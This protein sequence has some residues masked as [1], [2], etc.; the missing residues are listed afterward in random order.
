MSKDLKDLQKAANKHFGEGSV[1][2]YGEDTRTDVDVIPTGIMSLDK[3]LGIGGIPRGRMIEIF[4]PESTGKTTL[5]LYVAAQAQEQGGVVAYV[6]T[7]HSLDLS[8]AEILGVNVEELLISQPDTAEKALGIIEYL[9]KSGKVSVIVLDSIAAL[10]PQAE[11]EGDMGQ[12][13]IGLTA[14]LMSQACR[15]LT[16][17]L[18]ETNTS[19]IWINQ[20]R[21]KIGV[22]FGNPETTTGGNALKYYATM[23]LDVRRVQQLK[24]SDSVI[25][26]E[27]KVVVKKNKL[28]APGTLAKFNLLYGK[29]VDIIGDLF[30]L[31]VSNK[32]VDKAGAW[33]SYKGEKLGQGRNNACETLAN[34]E[35]WLTQVMEELN[36]SENKV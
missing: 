26:H 4:G 31:A 22:M 24:N 9:A 23:R 30:D 14:R 17:I 16:S 8:L 27:M 34:N 21:M 19:L 25:G 13:H 32:I 12:S 18:S 15:K 2:L 35:E 11:I 1:L 29:G 10:T 28:S 20:L 33:Y 7:E 36:G 6:D 3:A 5:A